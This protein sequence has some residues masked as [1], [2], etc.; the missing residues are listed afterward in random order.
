MNFF[1]LHLKK[2]IINQKL[3]K[4]GR[5]DNFVKEYSKKIFYIQKFNWNLIRINIFEI[6]FVFNFTETKNSE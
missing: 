3:T 5:I 2:I 6:F 1:F 4:N